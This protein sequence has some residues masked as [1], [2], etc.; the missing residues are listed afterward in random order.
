MRIS[1]LFILLLFTLGSAAQGSSVKIA[2]LK[3]NGGGDWYSDPTALPNLIEFCNENLHTNINPE[4]STIE[5]GSPELFNFPFVHLTGH[6]NIILSENDAMNL[7]VY[8]EGGG[9]LHIDDNYGLDEYIRRE[10]KK[11]FPDQ[12]FVELP[13]SHEIFHQKFDFNEG[14]PKIHEH[15]NK[16]PQAFGLF[17]DDRLVCFYTYETDLGDGWEDIDVHNDPE[18]LRQKALKM[19][20]NIIAYVFGQ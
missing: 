4:P 12:E 19:G 3:Y 16:Q 10:M 14:I 13:S 7:R 20:A 1:F 11:V 18:D 15:D 9:F 8:L 5:I 6:G 17:V 2:L